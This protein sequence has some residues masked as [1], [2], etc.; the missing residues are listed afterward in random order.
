M[1]LPIIWSLL[2]LIGI[3]IVVIGVIVAIVLAITY[4]KK[5]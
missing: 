5:K 2:A 1:R 3:G 4:G